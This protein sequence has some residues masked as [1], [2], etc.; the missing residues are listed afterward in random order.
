VLAAD[1]MHKIAKDA[2]ADTAD[3][4]CGSAT[5]KCSRCEGTGVVLQ[6]NARNTFGDYY[7]CPACKGDTLPPAPEGSE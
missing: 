4:S 6:M 3:A 7:I 5:P 2:L 1:T